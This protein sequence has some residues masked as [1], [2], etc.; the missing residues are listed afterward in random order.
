MT[1]CAA[2]WWPLVIYAALGLAAG[3][4]ILVAAMLIVAADSLDEHGEQR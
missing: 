4:A 3:C 1:A 2:P